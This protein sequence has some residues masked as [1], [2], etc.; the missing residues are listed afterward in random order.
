MQDIKNGNVYNNYMGEKL[1]E[2]FFPGAPREGWGEAEL[3]TFVDRLAN[4][5]VRGHELKPGEWECGCGFIYGHTDNQCG[6]C[7][8]ERPFSE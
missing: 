6:K 4:G 1:F 7:K 2:A 3:S 8:I 5:E